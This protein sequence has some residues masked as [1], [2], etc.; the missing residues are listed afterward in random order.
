MPIY[1]L[2]KF[3]KKPKFGA[4]FDENP[5]FWVKWPN[6][7]RGIHLLALV[8]NDYSINLLIFTVLIIK[9]Q[10]LSKLALKFGFCIKFTKKVNYH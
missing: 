2:D 1:F 6:L 3:M 5:I 9:I 10:F 4:N 8:M 7:D